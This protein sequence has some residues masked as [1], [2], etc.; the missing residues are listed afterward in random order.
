MNRRQFLRCVGCAGTATTAGC[1]GGTDDSYA[2]LERLTIVNI[3]ENPAAVDLRID[4][5]DTNETVYKNAYDL[6][7]GFDGVSVDCSWPDEPLE[8][9]SR[10]VGDSE[11]NT[12]STSGA[13][14]CATLLVELNEYGISHF[15]AV[16]ECRH[17]VRDCHFDR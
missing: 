3:L 5:E 12:Y 15:A 8:V 11:W 10:Q 4:R 16:E 17:A 9:M 7:A 14:G 2:T 13:N 6:P 1:L